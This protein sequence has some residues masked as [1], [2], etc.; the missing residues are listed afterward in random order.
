M[1]Q[2]DGESYLSLEGSP[3]GALP[4]PEGAG[5]CQMLHM[6]PGPDYIAFRKII[7]LCDDRERRSKVHGKVHSKVHSKLNITSYYILK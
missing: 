2:I 4:N 1:E 3:H 5:H 7:T 6:P